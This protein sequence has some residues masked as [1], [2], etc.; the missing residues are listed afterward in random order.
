[1]EEW[2]RPTLN[3]IYPPPLA[4]A[5]GSI[6]ETTS[7]GAPEMSPMAREALKGKPTGCK[8]HPDGHH[9]FLS[10]RRSDGQDL[11]GRIY[12]ELENLGFKPFYDRICLPGGSFLDALL[13]NI[14]S[15]PCFVPVGTKEW[16]GGGGQGKE[17][18]QMRADSSFPLLFPGILTCSE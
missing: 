9:C 11:V 7:N 2:V 17:G 1:M 5:A 8:F 18:G 4:P 14:R 12:A 16:V 10:Y 13:S 6:D 3:P 15:T